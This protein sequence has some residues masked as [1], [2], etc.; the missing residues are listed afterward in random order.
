MNPDE[1]SFNRWYFKRVES[2]NCYIYYTWQEHKYNLAVL[3]YSMAHLQENGEL[4]SYERKFG[5]VRV[6]EFADWVEYDC[7]DAM[8][9]PLPVAEPDTHALDFIKI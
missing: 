6:A 5:P 2:G 7:T 9:C 3:R 4:I 8:W 1:I